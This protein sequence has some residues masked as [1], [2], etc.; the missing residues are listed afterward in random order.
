MS[1][2]VEQ[3]PVASARSRHVPDRFVSTCGGIWD[4]VSEWRSFCY[5]LSPSTQPRNG[6]FFFCSCCARVWAASRSG[7]AISEFSVEAN[8]CCEAAEGRA[9]S[10]TRVPRNVRP[11]SRLVLYPTRSPAVF[12][13]PVPLTR[14]CSITRR[15]VGAGGRTVGV[16]I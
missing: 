11:P 13:R 15:T 12:I 7:A 6:Y 8:R 9:A 16:Q 5:C 10:K 4:A 3:W 2:E 14:T 1:N